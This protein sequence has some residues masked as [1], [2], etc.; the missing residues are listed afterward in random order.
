MATESPR[1]RVVLDTNSIVA[2][3]KS[4]NPS[5]PNIELLRRWE[6][7]QFD[8]LYSPD[9]RAEYAEKFVT[10]G[11]DAKRAERLLQKLGH[12]GIRIEVLPSD[13]VRV[14]AAD[15]DDDLILACAVKGAATHLVTYDP[16]FDFLGGSYRGIQ[17]LRP[18][19]FLYLLRGDASPDA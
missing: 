3:L 18:L 6:K 7:G 1:R 9:V 15:P 19:G 14:I 5:S 11:V 12:R 13:V 4:R 16:H 17:I 8:L 10:R 2:A